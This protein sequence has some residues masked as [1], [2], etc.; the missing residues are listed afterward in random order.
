MA[1]FQQIHDSRY[2]LRQCGSSVLTQ[3]IIGANN[4]ISLPSTVLNS[5]EC[6]AGLNFMDFDT[7][8]LT[9]CDARTFIAFSLIQEEITY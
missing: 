3:T 1:R 6:S 2:T 5:Q 7:S 9:I 4:A 8:L